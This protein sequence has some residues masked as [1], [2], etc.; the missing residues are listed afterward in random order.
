MKQK[1]LSLQTRFVILHAVAMIVFVV[2]ITIMMICIREQMYDISVSKNSEVMT[3]FSAGIENKL[4]SIDSEMDNFFAGELAQ[5]NFEKLNLGIGN[6]EGY[7]AYKNID[8][9]FVQQ[10]VINDVVEGITYYT[11]MMPPISFGYKSAAEYVGKNAQ[12]GALKYYKTD[13]N[14]DYI[15]GTKKIKRSDS[16]IVVS[17][18]IQR[19]LNNTYSI[20]GEPFKSHFMIVEND[21]ILY[22]DRNIPEGISLNYSENEKN[23]GN[24]YISHNEERYIVHYVCSAQTGWYYYN[25]VKEKDVFKNINYTITGILILIVSLFVFLAFL[26]YVISGKITRKLKILS[27]KI[28]GI[29]KGIYETLETDEKVNDFFDE[30]DSLILYYNS[31][32]T[33]IHELIDVDMKREIL[34]NKAKYNSL[35]TQINPH[36]LYNTLETVKSLALIDRSKDAADVVD[37]LSIL[38]RTCIELPEFISIRKEAELI[39]H[40]INIQKVRYG[41][42][43]CY[44]AEISEELKDIHIPCMLLQPLVENSIKHALE[45]MIEPCHITVCAQRNDKR[46]ILSVMD[47]G[48]GFAE[49]IE[50]NSVGIGLQYIKERL[51]LE[52]GDNGY[53]E[54]ENLVDGCIV[55]IIIGY[56]E[57]KANV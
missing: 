48:P 46:L 7:R 22:R 56:E 16:V 10:N 8:T 43:L 50:S 49:K 4:N 47:N 55:R 45:V 15:Y 30:T 35:K 36:F 54:M 14:S 1:Y 2:A 52:Y 41:N 33:R 12:D 24:R 17:L 9:M 31:M 44:K 37:E 39:E 3:V 32:V 42:R 34:L 23:R 20:Y 11:P 13:K 18:N 19:L 27:G 6:Y 25:I 40:Y 5:E 51:K 38:L 21:G 53:L 26:V 29:E 57:G 28:R